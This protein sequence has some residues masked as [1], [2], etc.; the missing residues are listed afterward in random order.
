MILWPKE[1][2]MTQQFKDYMNKS[3]EAYEAFLQTEY[4]S[5]NTRNTMMSDAVRFAHFLAGIHVGKN[6]QLG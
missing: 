2:I 4:P 1:D 5:P 3:L 6:E